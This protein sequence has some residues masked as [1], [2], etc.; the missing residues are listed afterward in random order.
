MSSM[1]RAWSLCTLISLLLLPSSGSAQTLASI[2]GIVRD[3]SGA[4]LPGVTVEASSPALIEKVRSVVTDGTGQ[5]RIVDLRSGVYTVTF[6]LP[7]FS[8]FKREGIELAGSFNATVNADLR[9]GALEET[10]T[11]TGESPIVDVQNVRQQSVIDRNVIASLPTSRS[12]TSVAG[13]NPAIQLQTNSGNVA[14]NVGGIDGPNDDRYVA[15]GSRIT[16]ARLQLDGLSIAASEGGGAGGTQ[17]MAPVS[18]SQEVV[19][20]TS[21]GMAEVE[22]AGIQ[23][24]IVPREGGNRFNGSTFATFTNGSLQG[25]N[26]TDELRARG[27]RAPNDLDKLWD[28]NPSFGGPLSRDK[29]WFFAQARHT[30]ADNWVAGMFHN[31]NAND[32]TKWTY[33]PDLSRQALQDNVWWQTALR[34]TWQATA[35]N[36]FSFF[37]DEQ[38]RCTSCDEGARPT[39]SPEAS[40]K[41][42]SYPNAISQVTWTSPVSNRLLAEAGIG[43]YRLRWGGKFR[44]GINPALIPVT[45]QAGAIP[46]LSYRAPN[47]A[48]LNW[49]SNFSMRAS[50]SYVTGTH[51]VKVG[52][53]QVLYHRE[54]KNRS[55]NGLSYRFNNGVPNQLTQS[56]APFDQVAYMSPLGLYA[57]D[58]WKPTPR[59][60]IQAGVRYDYFSTTFPEQTYGGTQFIPT[61]YTFAEQ[62]GAKLHDVTPRFGVAYDVF[63]NGKTA[64]KMNIGK[65]ML[66]QEGSS[67]TTVGAAVNPVARLS[68]STSRSWRDTNRNFV[69]DCDL[70]NPNANGECGGMA[71]RNFGTSN[72]TIAYDPEVLKG[73]GVRQYDWDFGATV[74]QELL[75]R[76]SATVGYFRRW[77]GNFIATDN[78]ARAAADFAFFDLPVPVDSRLPNSGGVVTGVP[79]VNPDKFGLVNNQVVPAK[80]FGK[81]IEH[82]DGVDVSI[83]AR[84]QNGLFLRGGLG[85]GR[86]LR[87][88]CEIAEKLPELLGNSPMSYCRNSQKLQTQVKLLSTYTIPRIDLQVSGTLQFIPG[89]EIQANYNAPNAVVAPLLGRPLS[90]NAASQTVSLLAP[91]SLYGDRITQLDLRVA[92]VL[93]FGGARALIGLDIFNALNTDAVLSQ[94]NTFGSRWLTPTAIMVGRFAKVSMQLDF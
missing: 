42:L 75:P 51:S 72:F 59:L 81:Q 33:E 4:V 22:T 58:Q 25:S 49:S 2:S 27:L 26:Y 78:L 71:N 90:G 29:L 62:E 1:R 83:D 20:T 77:Y 74:Q 13:L 52:Y 87:D 17:A 23:V 94:N 34:L 70:A 84:M 53:Q 8:T 79:N 24:N 85:T 73:W 6:T 19:V 31:K 44:K 60:T 67:A 65:Y 63:G 47:S 10:V 69:A 91:R 30:G 36:K 41:G 66:G 9:V 40:T 5:Y 38:Y 89:P 93:R 39:S 88:N 92:K 16:D 37:W 12:F 7:G 76:V 56:A 86:T 48:S 32:P 14:V 28:V 82:Y 64:V 57:Q 46:G 50:I 3:A 11:V 68:T 15:H 55:L 54:P 80:R 61:V 45:E 43:A 21:G 35:R 18:T